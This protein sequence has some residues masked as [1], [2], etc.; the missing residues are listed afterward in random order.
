MN[1]SWICGPAE[2]AAGPNSLS[3]IAFNRNNPQGPQVW[4]LPNLEV[5]REQG[6][7]SFGGVASADGLARM[8]AAAIGPLDGLAPL[9]DSETVAAV[10]QI[11]S[12]GYDLVN[13]GRK[14]F[15]AG[16]H[17]TSEYYPALGQGSFGHS[18]AGGQQAFADPRHGIAFGYTRGLFPFPAGPGRDCE[19][20]I[21]AS[22]AAA[23]AS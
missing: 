16:F 13:R 8:Y 7:A 21:S 5:I 4:E 20:L 3:G 23:G 10:G 2:A 9:L 1:A 12:S 18:G 15:T 6:P 17:A 14:A 22:Y 19:L 11:H